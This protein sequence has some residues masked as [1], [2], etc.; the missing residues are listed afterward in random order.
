MISLNINIAEL[1]EK[2]N[3]IIENYTAPINGIIDTI[4]QYTTFVPGESSVGLT[5]DDLYALAIRLPAEC[6]YLQAQINSQ[7][8]K[9]KVDSFLVET[10]VTESIVML[11][12]TK[13][14][15]KE[16][17][18]RAEAMSKEEILS[19]IVTQQIVAALQATII[20][21][22]KVYEGVKK[23]IDAKMRESNFDRKPGYPVN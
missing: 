6:S 18:R 12:S 22:D 4:L 1:Q 2:A 19:D 11:Q 20:R 5:M 7:L 14:D 3:N 9:Q 10:Q 13:G 15:A 16:R 21:A 17:Q 23:I 8:I